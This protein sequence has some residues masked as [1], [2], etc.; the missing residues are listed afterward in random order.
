MTNSKIN[1]IKL[2]ALG[3]VGEFGKNMYVVEVNESIFVID[4]GLMFPEEGMLGIDVVIPD[5]TYLRDNIEKVK[6]IFLTHGHEDHIGALEYILKDLQ[7]PVFGTELTLALVKAKFN[8]QEAKNVNLDLR[9]INADSKLSFGETDVS[10]FQTTHSIPGSV[11]VVVHTSDGAI[12]HTGDFKFDQAASGLYRT[13]IGKMDRLGDEGVLCLLS[14]STGAET[15]GHSTSE[16]VAFTETCRAFQHAPGRMIAACFAS[17]I[18]RVQ[19]IFAAAEKSNRKVA[20][21]GKSLEHIFDIALELGYLQVADDLIIPTSDL[22]KYADDEVLIL[23]T[24]ERGEPI[25]ALQKMARKTHAQVNIQPGDE[26]FLAASPI[27]GHELLVF[28]TIDLIYRAGGSVVSR[29]SHAHVSSHGSA[30]DLKLM[31][32]LMKPKY[33]VPVH[34]EERMLKGHANVAKSVGIPKEH[35][36]IP[37]KGDILEIKNK[38]MNLGGKVSANNILI[39]G[40]GIGDIGNIVLRDRRFLSQ[41]GILI[42]VVTLSRRQKR[43]VSGPEIISRGFIYVRESEKLIEEATKIVEDVVEK[44]IKKNNYDWTQIKQEMRDALY[45][46]LYDKTKRRP[47]ILPILMEV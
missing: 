3:G 13:E 24:G 27:R 15:P 41:D 38:K 39:D 18:N 5:I 29:A 17:D 2:I 32:N 20:V 37:Q 7:V 23:A 31:I 6:G 35:I 16:A 46:Y 34:G 12:V 11:G 22:G 14:D 47:M 44:N 36:F 42:A 1:N 9:E 10:F 45:Y 4:A 21:V 19:H 40:S 43:I 33:F 30:E 8:K 28:R 26:V 25:E